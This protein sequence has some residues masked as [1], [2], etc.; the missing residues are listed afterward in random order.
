MREITNIPED[1][2]LIL[3]PGYEI[4]NSSP[5]RK[6]RIIELRKELAKLEFLD[7]EESRHLEDPEARRGVQ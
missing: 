6:E 3:P 5:T 2:F 1:D 4:D 7:A